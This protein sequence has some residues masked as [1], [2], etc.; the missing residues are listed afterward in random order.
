MSFSAEFDQAIRVADQE[1]SVIYPPP[2]LAVNCH[3]W[4]KPMSGVLLLPD[5][6]RVGNNPLLDHTFALLEAE[7]REKGNRLV[8]QTGGGIPVEMA[9]TG[10]RFDE[11]V[12]ANSA[13]LLKS[14]KMFGSRPE[15]IVTVVSLTKR[16]LVQELDRFDQLASRSPDDLGGFEYRGLPPT[17][18]RVLQQEARIAGSLAALSRMIQ[19]QTLSM[20]VIAIIGNDRGDIQGALHFD[21]AGGHAVIPYDQSRP[22]SFAEE[23]VLRLMTVRSTHEVRSHHFLPSVL[24][25]A[26]WKE[27]RTPEAMIEAGGNFGDLG[28]FTEPFE[29]K[30]LT[31]LPGVEDAVAAQYS[32]GCLAVWD[33]EIGE[34]GA[35]L[36]TATGSKQTVD[37][38]RLQRRQIVPIIGIRDDGEGAIVLPVEGAGIV[39][40]SV[41]AV[42]LRR[43]IQRA[44]EADGGRQRKAVTHGHCGI[45]AYDPQHVEVIYLSPAFHKFPVTCGTKALAEATEE[46]FSRSEVLRNLKSGHGESRRIIVLQ[47]TCHGVVI[48]EVAD[49]GGPFELTFDALRR[50]YLTLDPKEVPQGS[51]IWEMRDGKF[52]RRQPP[53]EAFWV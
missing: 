32:T 49:D 45:V 22:L 25:V 38:R 13:L 24:P 39:Y 34:S 44:N 14:K 12:T 30:R 47:Q 33:P 48:L 36:T 27:L 26:V 23:I 21:L 42:E 43:I 10:A 46:A 1:R 4:V 9:I 18:V 16:E 3:E 7:L 37:K 5:Y 52:F 31:G 15:E 2:D 28:V 11:P 19:G 8:D 17:A 50:S 40:P 35:M 53:E 41:E 29:I 51:V 6:Y 20:R